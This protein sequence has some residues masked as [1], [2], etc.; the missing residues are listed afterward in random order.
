VLL[1]HD[2]EELLDLLTASAQAPQGGWSPPVDVA[3][4]DDRFVVRVDVPGTPREAL[5]VHVVGRRLLVA[6]AKPAHRGDERRRRYHRMER[7]FGTFSVEV[8]LPGPVRLDA[9]VA[10]LRAGVLEIVL[11]RVED[12]RGRAHAVPIVE[13]E[14]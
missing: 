2:V 4:L 9:A 7:S 10:A 6:G 3:E 1:Q 12:R 11:P 5:S 14:P 13:E 8:I